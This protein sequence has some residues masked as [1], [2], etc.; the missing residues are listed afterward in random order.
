MVVDPDVGLDEAV[1]A[2]LVEL[3]E[4]VDPRP[5]RQ[6]DPGV[7]VGVWRNDQMHVAL[8][9]FRSLLV[10]EKDTLKLFEQV[11]ASLRAVVLDEYAAVLQVVDLV[12]LGNGLVVEA[13][14]GDTRHVWPRRGRVTVVGDMRVVRALNVDVPEIRHLFAGQGAC[15]QCPRQPG[16][17]E[18]GEKETAHG[19]TATEILPSSTFTG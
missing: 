8:L 3:G 9:F 6:G 18:Q 11:G 13:P 2:C 10:L 16:G 14:R 19:A 12:F 7:H 17:R 5:C 15:S 4:R 1:D